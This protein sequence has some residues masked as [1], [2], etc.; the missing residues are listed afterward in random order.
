MNRPVKTR[1]PNDPY[2]QAGLQPFCPGGKTI[3]SMPTQEPTDTIVV[4]AMKKPVWSFKYGP[5]LGYFV[6]GVN[7]F[8][9]VFL[10]M[11]NYF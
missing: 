4:Y 7:R 10:F 1:P 6:S 2:C 3:D 8:Y 5:L 11:F 9:Q